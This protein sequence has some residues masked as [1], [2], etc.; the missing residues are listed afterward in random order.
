MLTLNQFSKTLI[1]AFSRH[2]E[3][4]KKRLENVLKYLEKASWNGVF[5]ISLTIF[6]THEYT[7]K[8]LNYFSRHLDVLKRRLENVLK[9]LEKAS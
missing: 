9:Y 1:I 6:K 7:F 5:K 2:L 8:T 4:L 3:V